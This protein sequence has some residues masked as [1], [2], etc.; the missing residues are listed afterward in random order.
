TLIS[1][2]AADTA[3]P[4]ADPPQAPTE[5][6]SLSAPLEAHPSGLSEPE[7]LA[8]RR[9]KARGLIQGPVSVGHAAADLA[10]GPPARP[11]SEVG[12]GFNFGAI[13]DTPNYYGNVGIQALVYGSWALD[14]KTEIF[15]T[16]E[17]LDS[18]FVQNATLSGTR[19]SLGNMTLGV[20]RQV[21]QTSAL[22]GA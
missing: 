16:L 6:P 1:Q 14:E 9:W 8:C 15:A 19:M 18:Q 22:A 12:L 21:Y 3:S 20:S 4:T 11:R 10:L 17:A 7:P 5:A 13:I 2:A